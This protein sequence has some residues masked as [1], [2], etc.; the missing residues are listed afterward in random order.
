MRHI[1]ILQV[2]VVCTSL[3]AHL[4]VLAVW[5]H[6]RPHPHTR[7]STDTNGEL[8]FQVAIPEVHRYTAFLSLDAQKQTFVFVE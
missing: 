7:G 4:Q 8:A 5:T 6:T 3:T 2:K 1:A